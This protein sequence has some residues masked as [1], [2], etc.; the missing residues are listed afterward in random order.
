[1]QPLLPRKPCKMF[2]LTEWLNVV[3][4]LFKQQLSKKKKRVTRD[5]YDSY[6]LQENMD[7]QQG[8]LVVLS[9]PS[10]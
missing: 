7:I 2:L 4:F 3:V 8:N 1:M 5:K 9:K 6:N 10:L